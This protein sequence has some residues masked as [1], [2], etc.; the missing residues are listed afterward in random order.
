[1]LL[2]LFHALAINV[3]PP[4]HRRTARMKT[5]FA[6]SILFLLF[7]SS[8]ASSTEIDC[9]QCHEELT[10][11]KSVH[12]AVSM[13]CTTC[14]TA[15]DA[16][17]IPHKMTT[18]TPKGLSAEQPDLCYGCHDKS[19]FNKKFVHAAI[20]MGC[21]GCH[22]PHASKYA[23]LLTSEPPDLCY[24]CHDKGMFTKKNVHP[25]VA[26]GQCT[27]CHAPHSSGM[28]SLLEKPVDELCS[29]C[30]DGKSSGKHIL[31]GYGLGDR[32]PTRG[33]PDPARPGKELSCTSCH[34]PHS[35]YG[36][37]LFPDEAVH[38]DNLCLICHRKIIVRP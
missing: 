7:L 33:R 6:L 27:A 30:H 12:A 18:K 29:T 34:S 4:E 28:A 5:I 11:G 32:H 21:T 38:S 1:M 17:D 15:V 36:K 2:A 35:S 20:G 26:A 10:K 9:L 31:A 25:P 22:N 16:R 14:H 8:R 37:F 3:I 19:L 13:G 23:K 24:A